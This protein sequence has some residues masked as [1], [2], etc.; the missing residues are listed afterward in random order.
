MLIGFDFDSIATIS[1]SASIDGLKWRRKI[2][3]EVIDADRNVWAVKS[4][5]GFRRRWVI[6]LSH[7]EDSNEHVVI[8]EFSCGFNEISIEVLCLLWLPDSVSFQLSTKIVFSLTPP[9]ST[10]KLRFRRAWCSIW[11]QKYFSLLHQNSRKNPKSSLLLL[12]YFRY[13]SHLTKISNFMF[14]RFYLQQ[15][16]LLYCLQYHHSLQGREGIAITNQ[17]KSVT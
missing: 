4:L 7:G 11:W 12:K 13:A 8:V 2:S 1:S 17:P 5:S 14:L 3:W 16:Y 10:R 9:I 15:Y 6:D